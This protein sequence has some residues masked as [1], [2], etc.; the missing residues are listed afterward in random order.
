MSCPVNMRSGHGFGA[1]LN[2]YLAKMVPNGQAGN[3]ARILVPIGDNVPAMDR[4]GR[5][6]HLVGLGFFGRVSVTGGAAGL[7]FPGQLFY[8]LLTAMSLMFAGRDAFVS[9]DG[10]DLDDDMVLREA[11][12]LAARPNDLGAAGGAVT[13][14]LSLVWTLGR[15]HTSEREGRA[16]DGAI[17]IALFDPSKDS[18]AGLRFTIGGTI[19]SGGGETESVPDTTSTGFATANEELEVYAIVQA[20]DELHI[21]APFQLRSSASTDLSGRYV[22][23]A[24]SNYVVVRDR[25][26]TAASWTP[27][28]SDY[29]VVTVKCGDEVIMQGLEGQ[30]ARRIARRANML[31]L[32]GD[33]GARASVRTLTP[34]TPE[35]LPLV[36]NAP[37]A[38][39]SDMANGDVGWTIGG[40]TGHARTRLLSRSYGDYDTTIEAKARSCTPGMGE[41]AV[42]TVAAAKASNKAGVWAPVLPVA[43]T[44]AK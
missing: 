20:E 24:V 40:R 44:P 42:R 36:W 18:T 16:L 34:A 19:S 7:A 10:A 29:S 13:R 11:D 4:A 41:G 12:L 9:I 38:K 43:V 6:N 31:T 21:D 2:V 8:T 35:Y 33:D 23:G 15:T 3:G 22:F 25:V 32:L 28:H 17:P 5:Y 14:D 37:G 30:T 1:K 27:N 26:N 39:R